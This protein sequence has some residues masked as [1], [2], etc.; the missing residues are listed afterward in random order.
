MQ[1][2][3]TLT[4]IITLLLIVPISAEFWACAEKGEFIDYCNPKTPDRTCSSSNGCE[5]CMKEYDETRQCYNQGN[6]RI[7]QNIDRVCTDVGAVPVIDSNPP[8]FTLL[9]PLQDAIYTSRSTLIEFNLNEKAS[10]YYKNNLDDRDRWVRICSSCSPGEPA[11]SRR[12]SFKEGFNDLTFRAIDVMGLETSQDLT[13]L[14]DSRKPRIHRTLPRSGYSNG[15]FEVQYTEDNLKIVE[16]TFGNEETGFE[17][18]KLSDCE[19]GKR[20]WCDIDI[21]LEEF[22]NQRIEYWFDITDKAGNTKKSQMRKNLNV[23]TVFPV[24]NK[25]DF[26]EQGEGRYNRYIYFNFD[27]TEENLDKIVYI[28]TDS[29]DRIRERRLCSR[30][31]DGICKTKKTFRTGNHVLDI[32]IIDKAGNSIERTIEFDV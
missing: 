9:S 21:N 5:Y 30:L 17:T 6:W 29:R 15:L 28:Y 12:K 25:E 3:I 13:F 31:K 24:L 2:H 4:L 23:D 32:Q 27:V 10:V 19:S 14:I 7:C 20:V 11:Y 22:N 26:W 8:E 18:I 16:I 1:K